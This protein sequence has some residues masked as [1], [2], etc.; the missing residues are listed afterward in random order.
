M[1]QGKNRFYGTWDELSKFAPSDEVAKRAVD[2]INSQVR[3][4]TEESDSEEEEEGQ[5]KREKHATTK[6]TKKKQI[7]QK[8]TR[9]HGVSSLKTWENSKKLF[10]YLFLQ[11]K[12]KYSSP[13][14]MANVAEDK[15]F[16]RTLFVQRIV[17]S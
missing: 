6:E 3:E 11:S 12:K 8:D 10:A 13:E 2:H 5:D 7:M 14:R 4:N 16:P 17:P 1:V 9:E 15:I